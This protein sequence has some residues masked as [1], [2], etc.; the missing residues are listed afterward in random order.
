L[1][2]WRQRR[3][4]MAH[5]CVCLDALAPGMSGPAARRVL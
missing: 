2:E 3:G 5:C 4:I 1:R